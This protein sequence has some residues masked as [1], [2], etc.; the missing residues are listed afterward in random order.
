MRVA[1]VGS[2]RRAADA[3]RALVFEVVR[4]LVDM[5]GETNLHIVSGGCKTGADQ[6]AKE[7]AEFFSLP[8]T[9]HLPYKIEPKTYWEAVTMLQ[10]RNEVVILDCDIVFALIA[11]DRKG[12][13][14]NALKHAEKH[15]KPSYLV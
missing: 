2:R 13:T 14:E 15:G 10:A 1:I 3:D 7:A 12:G 11:A 6:F 8:F 5:F 4:R 9:E